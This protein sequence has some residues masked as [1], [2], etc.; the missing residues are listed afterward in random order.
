MMQIS[1]FLILSVLPTHVVERFVI[2]KLLSV[3]LGGAFRSLLWFLTG[4]ESG[5]AFLQN[6]YV[7]SICEG[8]QRRRVVSFNSNWNVIVCNRWRRDCWLR[9]KDVSPKM[10]MKGCDLKKDFFS[11][12]ISHFR[13]LTASQERLL[14]WQKRPLLNHITSNLIRGISHIYGQCRH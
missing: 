10:N 8:P 3:F 5:P 12:V 9:G 13:I 4:R 7:I 11:D 14:H 1:T 2:I 6:L